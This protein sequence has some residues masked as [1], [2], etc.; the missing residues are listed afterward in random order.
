[1]N[2]TQYMLKSLS[3]LFDTPD[4]N[5]ESLILFYLMYVF[6]IHNSLTF[7]RILITYLYTKLNGCE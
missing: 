7:Q 6:V 2:S 1:M 5:N 3:E 4:I